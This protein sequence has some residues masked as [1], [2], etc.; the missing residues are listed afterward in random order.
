L[1]E[2]GEHLSRN[3]LIDHRH[4]SNCGEVGCRRC[5]AIGVRL[6]RTVSFECS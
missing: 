5:S 2:G 4:S 3:Q 1:D 6:D